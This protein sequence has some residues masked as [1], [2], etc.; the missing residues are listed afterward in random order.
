MS[1][2]EESD[3]IEKIKLNSANENQLYVSIAANQNAPWIVNWFYRNTSVEDW[4]YVQ[5]Q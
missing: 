3:L 2:N 4:K 1:W 5:I